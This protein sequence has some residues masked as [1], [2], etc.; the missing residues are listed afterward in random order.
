MT[1]PRILLLVTFCRL[2]LLIDGA[3][4]SRFL[5]GKAFSRARASSSSVLTPLLLGAQQQENDNTAEENTVTDEATEQ[6]AQELRQRAKELKAQARAMEAALGDT[7]TDTSN[8]RNQES[9]ALVEQLFTN[10]ATSVKLSERLLEERWSPDQLT[11]V[12][13][14]LHERQVQALGRN[15]G[16]PPS[17]GF[18]IGDTS[19][20]A[21]SDEEEW[22]RLDA[23]IEALLEAAS[24]L[25]DQSTANVNENPR[26]TSGRVANALR[27]RLKELRR[28]DEQE[29]QRKL[30]ASVNVIAN[31]NVSVQEY[32]SGTLGTTPIVFEDKATGK[33]LILEQVS[34]VPMWVPSS[35]LPFLIV[36]RSKLESEDLKTIRDKVLT[37]TN[38]YCTSSE[39]IPGAAIFRG[40]VRTP[41]DVVNTTMERN[42][43]ALIFEDI[44]HRL[45]EDGLSDRVQL[46]FW[47]DPEWR[48]GRDEREASPKPVLLALPTE[49][50]P[51][52]SSEGGY[53]SLALKVCGYKSKC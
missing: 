11:L 36:T 22:N 41:L 6:E 10:N 44:Q 18:Q 1:L 42:H 14:R 5:H 13:E 46:F 16:K 33:S 4:S 34:Q 9:D 15:A 38:F 21:E 48:P 26:W 30:A 40:N 3:F 47:N 25:D 24:I 12:I 19:N 45:A 50:V 8:R 20:K 2:C 39:S 43:T 32:M 49:V 51:E 29:F 53:A 7:R 35:L 28:T 17:A 27:S 37:G 52:Q 31:T 23:Q